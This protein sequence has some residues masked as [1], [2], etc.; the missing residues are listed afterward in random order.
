[1]WRIYHRRTEDFLPIGSGLVEEIA[2]M[3]IMKVVQ[4]DI[5]EQQA[6]AFFT[7]PN[8][9]ILEKLERVG[10]TQ[11]SDV[12]MDAAIEFGGEKL[13]VNMTIFIMS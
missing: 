1:M 10:E 12:A 4:A 3:R 6:E 8:A 2:G 7:G 5:V 13:S 11:A 9:W